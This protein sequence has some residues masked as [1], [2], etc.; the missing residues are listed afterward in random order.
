MVTRGI[1]S[2]RI[3]IRPTLTQATVENGPLSVLLDILLLYQGLVVNALGQ[4]VTNGSKPLHLVKLARC[5]RGVLKQTTLAETWIS[6][7]VAKMLD[8]NICKSLSSVRSTVVRIEDVRTTSAKIAGQK[9]LVME[10]EFV[11]G[12]AVRVHVIGTTCV[13][14][15]A[16][17]QE[18]D[19]RLD[20][21]VRFQFITLPDEV[22]DMCVHL[23][24]AEGLR[25]SGID[26]VVRNDDAWVL[27]EVN[28][29][30][31]FHFFERN[32]ADRRHSR[33][34]SR[35]LLTYLLSGGGAPPFRC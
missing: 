26:F 1:D 18:I 21:A 34:I 17:T 3:F 23:T 31:A 16:H 28:P 27:M 7:N 5:S 6:T 12:T 9:G 22:R 24:Q 30:P 25:L 10:Q 33:L 19:Y 20:G 2:V 8:S 29:T 32:V 11:R 4:S 14:F 15:R 35:I 13:A